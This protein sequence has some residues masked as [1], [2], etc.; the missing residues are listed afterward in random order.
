MHRGFLKE[1][2][3]QFPNDFIENMDRYLYGADKE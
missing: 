1:V 3:G 2:S